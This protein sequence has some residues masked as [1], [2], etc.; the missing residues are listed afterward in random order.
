M[1]GR[2][3]TLSDNRIKVARRWVPCCLDASLA[4]RVKFCRTEFFI[5]LVSKYVLILTDTGISAS[6][7][8]D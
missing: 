1:E 8:S 7:K 6:N 4:C 2:E 5:S 3:S